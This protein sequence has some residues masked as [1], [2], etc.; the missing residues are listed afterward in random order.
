MYEGAWLCHSHSVLEYWNQFQ[1]VQPR[2]SYQD[3][4]KH[5]PIYHSAGELYLALPVLQVDKVITYVTQLQNARNFCELALEEL[6][7]TMGWPELSFGCVSLVRHCSQMASERCAA[8]GRQYLGVCEACAPRIM[9]PRQVHFPT[10]VSLNDGSTNEVSAKCFWWGVYGSCS[11]HHFRPMLQLNS[12]FGIANW[13][14][15]LQGF[16]TARWRP[17]GVHSKF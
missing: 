15:L 16:L 10:L 5:S 13:L 7:E 1:K 6:E 9:L 12:I 3:L 2:Q 4:H 17:K 14:W 8:A 11:I